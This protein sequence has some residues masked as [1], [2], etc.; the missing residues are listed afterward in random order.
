MYK[1]LSISWGQFKQAHSSHCTRF[2]LFLGASSSRATPHVLHIVQGFV[3]FLGPVQTGPLLT[4]FTLYKVL[5]ISWGQFKQAHS[6]RPS[7]CTRFCRFLGAISNKP[8]PH[9][10][11]GFVYFL[12]PVQ[13][14]PLLTSFTLY[15]VL[16]ISLGQFKQAHSS[17]CTRFCLFL[18]ASSSRPTPHILHIVQGFVYFLGP[19][20]AG[21]LLT[22]Y[23]VLSIS[24]GQFK[25]AHSSRPSHCTRFCLFLGA[26]SS[27]PTPHVLH[28][29]QGFVYFLGP[30]QTGPLLT[31]F[32]LYKVLSISWG[33]FKQVHS[34]HCTRFCL[35]LGASS[36]RPTPHVLHI[37]QGFVYFLGPVQTGPLLTSFTLYKVL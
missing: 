35:F 1:V 17:H 28:I 4:S 36:S 30:V 11:Q 20:Q 27:R 25:Q 16:S 26:S 10:V 15:K 18:G 6:S 8:T 2:C 12:G 13:T 21:P 9:I 5:S 31:S 22:L 19:V 37:V 29:V 24:W 23:K 33:H 14:G 3:Y 32:T 34:S 7:H